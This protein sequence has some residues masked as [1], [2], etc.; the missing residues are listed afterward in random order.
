[1]GNTGPDGVPEK[2]ALLVLAILGLTSKHACSR[3]VTGS[4]SCETIMR[5]RSYSMKS[6]VSCL[7]L[8]AVFVCAGWGSARASMPGTT[9]WSKETSGGESAASVV[10]T[11]NSTTIVSRAIVSSSCSGGGPNGAPV[12]CN[13]ASANEI[14]SFT[15]GNSGFCYYL[16]KGTGSNGPT[17]GTYSGSLSDNSIQV[18][19]STG[20]TFDGTFVVVGN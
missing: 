8:V 20:G 17:C 15:P 1:M 9:I 16:V 7:A 11:L 6:M 14:W 10:T 3:C 2:A 12:V 18:T 19:L 5:R 4:H 13:T